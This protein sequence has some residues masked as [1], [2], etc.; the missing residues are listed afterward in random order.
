MVWSRDAPD[1]QVLAWLRRAGDWEL[2]CHG[3][4]VAAERARAGRLDSARRFVQAAERVL[5]DDP[6]LRCREVLEG[7]APAY[8]RLGRD[9][10][11][12][13][14]I[15]ALRDE[16]DEDELVHVLFGLAA[17]GGRRDRI[18]ALLPDTLTDDA[19][20]DPLCHALPALVED[21]FDDVV[22]EL[23]RRWVKID[24]VV[25]LVDEPAGALLAAHLRRDRPAAFLELALRRP[26]FSEYLHRTLTAAMVALERKDAA[27]AVELAEALLSVYQG[28]AAYPFTAHAVAV[29][30]E[31]APTRAAAWEVANAQL[32]GEP[33]QKL[34]VPYLAALGRS[35]E[36]RATMQG[37]RR[38]SH[39]ELVDAAWVTR[40]LALATELLS[41]LLAN[42]DPNE[43]Y[44]SMGCDRLAW[45]VPL[46][47]RGPL[48]AALEARLAEIRAMKPGKRDLPCRGL[49]AAAGA[50]GRMDI[51]LK[52]FRLPTKAVRR[53]S[54]EQCVEGC[55]AA[56]DWKN[57]LT[58]LEHLDPED[59]PGV[60]LWQ[61][62]RY[63]SDQV[64]DY[65]AIPPRSL[66]REL[67][68]SSPIYRRRG[69]G[70]PKDGARRA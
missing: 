4:R 23:L 67:L 24:D 65:T 50:V 48:D 41:A 20:K 37:S 58:A 30:A 34:R 52:C 66:D 62:S 27:R 28:W 60:A 51:A 44:A 43:G 31:H 19:S 7:L 47:M 35:A 59:R 11:A 2:A 45:L 18:D 53:Y 26:E 13:A 49:A 29:L 14:A 32:L 57:A 16:V 46:G 12:D 42:P 8:L 64:D 9:A 3:S 36:A 22:D 25:I 38:L 68:E 54:V 10:D 56:G 6:E 40:D 63:D 39:R 69:S 70:S 55:A 33:T 15:A 17:L 61:G 21:G 5:A 1:D